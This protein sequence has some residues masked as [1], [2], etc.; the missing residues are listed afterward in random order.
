MINLLLPSDGIEFKKWLNVPPPT[1][2]RCNYVVRYGGSGLVEAVTDSELEEYFNSGEYDDRLGEI[3]EEEKQESLLSNEI[4]IDNGL[5]SS[6]L[7]LPIS[8]CV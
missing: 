6:V 8:I 1:K 5:R 2:E 7:Y 3:E 4:P